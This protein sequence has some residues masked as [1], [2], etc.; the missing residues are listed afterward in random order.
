MPEYF[1][2]SSSSSSSYYYNSNSNLNSNSSSFSSI[3]S[4]NSSNNSSNNSY[5]SYSRNN[6]YQINNNQQNQQRNNLIQN[7]NN[8]QN[9]RNINNESRL[10]DE[11]SV[12]VSSDG[13]TIYLESDNDY[14]D[15]DILPPI[16][17]SFH[18]NHNHSHNDRNNNNNNTLE[19]NE[20]NLS[21]D[22]FDDYPDV[23][24]LPPVN[25]NQSFNSNQRNFGLLTQNERENMKLQSKSTTLDDISRNF[26]CSR[27]GCEIDEQSIINPRLRRQQVIL[28]FTIIFILILIFNF[29][30]R[31]IQVQKMLSC[32]VQN[33]EIQKIIH[34]IINLISN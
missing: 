11:D 16:N 26:R 4:I 15:V 14:P 34:Y 19:E 1:N 33:V 24:E 9:N 23:D 31:L 20:I 10:Y 2:N 12:I 7:N 18:H 13:D 8:I 32:T 25:N 5:S 6:N 21:L 17:N 30:I 27:A 3:Y 28:Y 22:E 29:I